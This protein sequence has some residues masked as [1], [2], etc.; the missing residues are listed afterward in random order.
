MTKSTVHAEFKSDIRQVWDIVTSLEQYGWRSDLSKIEVLEPGKTFVEY[1]KDHFPTRFTITAFEPCS[2]YEFDMENENMSGH[3]S[4][5]FSQSNGRTCIEF[6]ENVTAKKML[7]KPFVKG[8][9]QK[10]Q[11]CYIEDLKR[12]LKEL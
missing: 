5:L 8:F 2:R 7:M 3:W 6:T 12:V 9:L 4:G 11:A 10:Q 1:T